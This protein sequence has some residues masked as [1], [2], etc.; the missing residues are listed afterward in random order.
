MS[1]N[2]KIGSANQGS[3]IQGSSVHIIEV[4][5]YMLRLFTVNKLCAATY[6]FTLTSTRGAIYR[7]YNTL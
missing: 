5:K 6:L 4:D 1:T 3:A 2:W 7:D